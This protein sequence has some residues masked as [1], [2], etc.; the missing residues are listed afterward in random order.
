[1]L[2]TVNRTEVKGLT[3]KHDLLPKYMVWVGQ[4]EVDGDIYLP[5]LTIGRNN[6]T[7]EK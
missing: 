3:F 5:E 4:W 6:T 2:E 1:M 7:V